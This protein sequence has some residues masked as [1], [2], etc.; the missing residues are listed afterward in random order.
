LDD[1]Y[2]VYYGDEV[3]LAMQP[4]EIAGNGRASCDVTDMSDVPLSV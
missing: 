1:V 2:V 3:R 4:S